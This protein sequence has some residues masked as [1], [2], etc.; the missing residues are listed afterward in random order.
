MQRP[1]DKT[2]LGNFDEVTVDFHGV[3]SRLFR[4][5]D[6][7]MITTTGNNGKPGTF[8]IEYT[9]GHYPVQQYLVDIGN[10]HLQALNIAWDSRKVDQGGQRWYHLQNEEE[11]DPDHPFFWTRHFQNANSRCIECH[12]TDFRKN[13]DPESRG[14]TTAWKETGVGCE[15][16]HGPAAR[17]IELARTGGLNDHTSGFNKPVKPGL[18]WAF[19]GDDDIASP[20]GTLNN[21]YIDTCGGCHSRRGAFGDVTPQ[22]AYHDHYRLALLEPGLYFSDGQIDDEV[23]VLG[24]FLQSKMKQR[25][26]TCANCHDPH[27]GKTLAE[28]NALCAQCHQPAVFDSSDHHRHP[29]ASAGAQCVNCHMPERLYMGVDWRRD[30]GFSIP[31]PEHASSLGAPNACTNCHQDK[32]DEWAKDI[33]ST[34]GGKRK[35]DPWARINR[36]LEQR[37][38]L[39][40]KN[41][42]Q[43]APM[44]DLASIRQ[45]SL[46]SKLAAFPSQ[47]AF[48]TASR[49][50]SNADPLERRAA[51]SALAAAPLKIRWP[52]LQPLI[53][54]PV[55]AVRMEVAATLA[56][57]LPQLSTGDAKHLQRLLDEYRDY[58]EY[59]ADTPGG[60]LSLGNLEARLGYPELAEQ[61]YLQALEIEPHF[62]PA[63]INLGDLYRSIGRDGE[64]KDLLLHALEVAPDSAL[65]NHAWGLFLVRSGRQSE[66]MD[67]LKAAIELEGTNPRHLY[68]YAVALDSLGQTNAAIQ[69]IDANRERWPNNIDLSFLQVS[70]MDKTGD[71]ESIHRYLSLLATVAAGNPQVR[72]WMSKY[73]K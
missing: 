8:T 1:D 72:T 29:P 65:T 59:I 19:R 70:Y 50:L 34:R 36:G 27:S 57:A 30:H 58:L 46:T 66:A 28:G 61:A 67:Y 45:A 55:K 64:S 63:L 2:V 26:V 56:E 38:A 6:N 14:Y 7:F 48:E 54:D 18:T 73:G 20:S 15:S 44:I 42:A 52:L 60:Q 39:V 25:G 49:Q 11:I 3:E 5:G 13:Y 40:F 35:A 51:V 4:Q 71:N 62:V 32:S 31:D 10:G 33:V 53:E 9:F 16:C 69:L 21:D 41:Y 68:V 17:H 12:S 22:S 23:F 37:D 24:S 43:T 47:L